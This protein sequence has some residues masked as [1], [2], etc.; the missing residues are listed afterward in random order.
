MWK[1]RLSKKKERKNK[2][3]TGAENVEETQK[4]IQIQDTYTPRQGKF[5]QAEVIEG[6]IY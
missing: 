5:N 2:Q 3:K 4:A 6:I 1:Q